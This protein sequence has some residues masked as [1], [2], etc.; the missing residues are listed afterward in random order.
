MFLANLTLTSSIFYNV[1]YMIGIIFFIKM[2][3]SKKMLKID[4]K[5][6]VDVTILQTLHTVIQEFN[7]LTNQKPLNEKFR[8]ECFIVI[9]NILLLILNNIVLDLLLDI[10]LLIILQSLLYL[11]FLNLLVM[12][13]F[14]KLFKGYA[15]FRHFKEFSQKT[16]FLIF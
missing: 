3:L 15:M 4:V 8:F 16:H 13:L 5:L 7:N 9:F 14:F 10:F 12:F 1:Y 6:F 11:F 2:V